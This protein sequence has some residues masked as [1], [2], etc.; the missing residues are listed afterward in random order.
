MKGPTLREIGIK[1]KAKINLHKRLWRASCRSMI[2]KALEGID[3]WAA[4]V[5]VV[6]PQ[7]PHGMREC[8]AVFLKK[9]L[10]QT[11]IYNK[12]RW[13]KSK[14]A[15]KVSFDFFKPFKCRQL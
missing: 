5:S 14:Q 4:E 2:V 8:N 13:F 9:L 1:A 6:F 10:N 15:W 7:A 3:D 12:L 11:R